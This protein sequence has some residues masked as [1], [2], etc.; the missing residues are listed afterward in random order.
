MTD[1]GEDDVADDPQLAAS[2]ATEAAAHLEDL[3]RNQDL[4]GAESAYES[5]ADQV[6]VLRKHLEDFLKEDRRIPE[7][8]G[9]QSQ[10]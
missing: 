8:T 10:S 2:R 7:I 5:L 6:D 9:I 1:R 3:A 4:P